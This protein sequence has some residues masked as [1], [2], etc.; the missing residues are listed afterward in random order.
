MLT[1]VQPPDQAW[2]HGSLQLPRLSIFRLL[3]C[4]PDGRHDRHCFRPFLQSFNI[5]E[6]W[7]VE[8][9]RYTSN[10]KQIKVR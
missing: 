2:L 7:V 10:V 4:S 9:G 5:V 6:A 8:Y 1:V 3:D